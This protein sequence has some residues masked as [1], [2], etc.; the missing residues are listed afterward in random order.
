MPMPFV[1]DTDP[2]PGTGPLGREPHRGFGIAVL[3]G[4]GQ[5]VGEDLRQPR[6]VGVDRQAARRDGHLEHLTAAFEHR[7]R[8]LDRACRHLADLDQFTAQLDLAAGHARHVQQVVDETLEGGHLPLDHVLLARR[9]V[10]EAHQLQCRQDRRQRIAQLVAEHGQELVLRLH[11]LFGARVRHLQLA[12]LTFELAQGPLDLRARRIERVGQCLGLA[13]MV[14]RDF[15]LPAGRHG[16]VLA[17]QHSPRRAVR[18]R[19]RPRCRPRHSAHR[20]TP[21]AARA[22]AERAPVC[23]RRPPDSRPR[24]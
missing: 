19:P 12:G 18:G 15:E 11:R 2:D 13:R 23:G 1:L 16:Q 14:L 4:V 20:R 22:A 10:L 8:Q 7:T 24:P 21:A 6:R 5:E 3:G 9:L 17:P